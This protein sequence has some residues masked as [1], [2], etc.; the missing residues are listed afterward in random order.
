M[1]VKEYCCYCGTCTNVCPQNAI[2]LMDRVIVEIDQE[3][4]TNCGLCARVCPVG[5]IDGL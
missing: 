3:A 5:A 2:E 1:F 4:C